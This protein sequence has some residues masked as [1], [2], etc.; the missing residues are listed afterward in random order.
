MRH[1]FSLVRILM[2]AL[3]ISSCSASSVKTVPASLG[4]ATGMQA[5]LEVANQAGPIE[6]EKHTAAR[7]AVPLS[8][9]LDLN[10]PKA[11]A[12]GLVDRD[13]PI[14]LFVYTLRHPQH[15]TYLLDSGVS[16]R[17]IDVENNSDISYVVKKAMNTSSLEALLTTKAL[18]L[19]Y[20]G[21]QGVLLSHIHLDHIM[22][23]SDIDANVEVYIGPGDTRSTSLEHLATR[24]TTNRLLENISE[25]QEWQ[26]GDAGVVDVFGDGSL[27]AISSSGH[28]PGSTA[29]LVRSTNGPQLIIGDVTHTRWGWDNQVGP[30]S[31]S[32]DSAAGVISLKRL[33]DLC[34]NNPNIV[35][36]PGHQN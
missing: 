17:F 5:L 6:F 32:I 20:G 33:K 36:H 22:G 15:G 18:I 26:F 19:K 30:G 29:Y 2:A 27:W 25:L 4:K 10:H 16:E 23:I 3:F 9:M 12:A 31:Y 7:W 1:T 34:I 35:V 24:G 21:I 14:E 8:G 13:E 28:T 11:V